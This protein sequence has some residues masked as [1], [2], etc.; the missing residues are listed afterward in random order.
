[1][2]ALNGIRGNGP[3]DGDEPAIILLGIE[4]RSYYVYKGDEFLNQLLLVDG[5]FPTPILCVNFDT[6]F[7]AKRVIG[8][9]FS[10]AAYWAIHPEI[11]ARLRADKYLIEADE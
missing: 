9:G 5:E 11:I 2:N 7:D 3:N 4:K 10:L 1:M 8:G 6:I